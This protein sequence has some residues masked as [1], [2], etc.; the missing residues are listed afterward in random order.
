MRSV[1][2]Q[3]GE[4]FQIYGPICGSVINVGLQLAL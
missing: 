3:N 1:A 2:D 4:N